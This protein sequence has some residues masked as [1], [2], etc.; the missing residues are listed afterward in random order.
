MN[1][2]KQNKSKGQR[3]PEAPQLPRDPDGMND[4]RAAWA[5]RAIVEFE[6]ATRTDREDALA[7]LLAD[8]FHW[9]DRNGVD[10]ET[11]LARGRGN[12][13]EETADPARADEDAAGKLC[14]FN[15]DG[16]RVEV[17]AHAQGACPNCG[18]WRYPTA[19]LYVDCVNDCAGRGFAPREVQ[20]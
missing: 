17:P 1:K 15:A 4:K 2:A 6:R 20:P 11:E 10:F 18:Q 5:E 7:D 3:P 8:L 14:Y 19:K 13:E 16:V 9:C 12:Y